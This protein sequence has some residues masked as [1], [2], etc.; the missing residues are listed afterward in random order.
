MTA[1]APVEKKPGVPA[2]VVHRS[3]DACPTTV[4]VLGADIER[5]R[6]LRSPDVRGNPSSRRRVRAGC[7]HEPL[8][9]PVVDVME[10]VVERASIEFDGCPQ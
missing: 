3:G 7:R 2:L 9:H 6:R 4:A 1:P 10:P 8:G 5:W